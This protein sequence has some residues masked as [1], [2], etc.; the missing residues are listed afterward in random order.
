MW[1]R[2]YATHHPAT[3]LLEKYA[4]NGCPVD[5]GPRWTKEQIEAAILQHGPYKSAQ[6]P[7]AREALRAEAKDKVTQGFAKIV[8]YKDIQNNLPET[9]K[10]SPAACIPHK[11]RQFCVIL[12]LSFNLL[13]NGSAKLQSTKQ[14]DHKHHQK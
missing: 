3:P 11:S 12:D 8:K 14:Q 6:L 1:P 13:L 5:C 2:T 4:R 10:I 7:V 9:L